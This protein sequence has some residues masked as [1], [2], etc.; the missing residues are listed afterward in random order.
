MLPDATDLIPVLS[1]FSAARPVF[2]FTR[3]T[4]DNPRAG[5]L[6]EAFLDF[7]SRRPSDTFVEV[8]I[9]D[10]ACP[11]GESIVVIDVDVSAE[12]DELVERS[13]RLVFFD[14][15]VECR[16]SVV[17]LGNVSICVDV[18]I[19]DVLSVAV[20]RRSLFVDVA[21]E[22]GAPECVRGQVIARM[23]VDLDCE[24]AVVGDAAGGDGDELA[25][26]GHAKQRAVVVGFAL[27]TAQFFYGGAWVI[28]D[29][30]EGGHGVSLLR[31]GFVDGCH[32]STRWRVAREETPDQR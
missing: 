18:R 22:V 6:H 29:V 2:C 13:A 7:L 5:V 21:D 16:A 26:G 17:H 9:G 32:C 8:V 31:V 15:R 20:P 4:D 1:V 23:V 11:V 30:V 10:G 24:N 19:V 12:A 27:E 3:V 28:L 25:D 14:G